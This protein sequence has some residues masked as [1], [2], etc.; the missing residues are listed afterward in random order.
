MKD[1]KIIF[2]D[3]DGVL[4]RVWGKNRTDFRKNQLEPELVKHLE[5]II[6]ATNASIIVS[7]AWRVFKM[8]DLY[9]QLNKFGFKY[10]DRII[11]RTRRSVRNKERG[12]EILDKVN[13]MGLQSWITLED[14]PLHMY[15]YLP[16]NRIIK[17]HGD[18]GLIP[19]LVQEAI[20]A[21]NSEE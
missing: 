8:G 6:D 20:S 13:E 3:V 4:N 12:L 15:Q 19:E 11:A 14:E 5:E 1:F 9:D 16:D 10:C 7:S 18:V 17:T 2:L 21:L